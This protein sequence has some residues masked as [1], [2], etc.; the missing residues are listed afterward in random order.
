MKKAAELNSSL[1]MLHTVYARALLGAGDHD[2]A[3]REL[4]R[5]LAAAHERFRSQPRARRAAAPRRASSGTALYLRRAVQLRP[6]DATARF[7]LAGALLS[8][9]ELEESVPLLEKVVVDVPDYTAAHVMLAT[10]YY[11]LKRTADGDRRKR[12]PSAFA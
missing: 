3:V 1:P 2:G 5:A 11:R 12:S 6:H 8:L 4:R 9:G 7:G 10:C